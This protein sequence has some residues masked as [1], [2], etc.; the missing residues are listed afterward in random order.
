MPER[1]GA[2]GVAVHGVLQAL[3]AMTDG[4]LTACRKCCRPRKG[5]PPIVSGR[6]SGTLAVIGWAVCTE[7]RCYDNRV[8]AQQKL[9]HLRSRS[10]QTCA[11]FSGPS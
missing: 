9:G 11:N 5:R 7:A 6:V 2:G 8:F 1:G 10:S 3:T 4:A